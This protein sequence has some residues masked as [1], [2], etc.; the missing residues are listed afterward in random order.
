[1]ELSELAQN[2]VPGLGSDFISK[3]KLP[4]ILNDQDYV[5]MQ[6]EGCRELAHHTGP[7]VPVY[8]ALVAFCGLA[9]PFANEHPGWLATMVLLTAVAGLLRL[10]LARRLLA[11][12]NGIPPAL[13]ANYRAATLGVACSWGFF[14]AS[15]IYWYQST[16]ASQLAMVVSVGLTAGASSS[17]VSDLRLFQVYAVC[18]LLPG[19]ILLAGV[20]GQEA[21]SCV[22][23]FV[24][25]LFIMATGRRHNQR[26][27]AAI[28][29]ERLLQRRTIELE[30]ANLAKSEFVA[31]VSHE[32]RTPMNAIVGMT[33]LLLD[34]PLDPKQRE[35]ATTLRGGCET[36]LTIINDILDLSKME[37]T[38]LELERQPLDLVRLLQEVVALFEPGAYQRGLLLHH[39]W[40]QL[41]AAFWVRG[42]STRLRQVVS[43][44]LSNA[45]KF[46][47]EGSVS[48]KV[49]RMS[50]D[51]IQLSIRDTG[52]GLQPDRMDR[53]FRP[54]SQQDASITR[55]YGGTGLGLAVCDRLAA[56]MGGACWAVSG[57]H[58]A[59]RTPADFQ[60]EPLE[61]GSEFYFRWACEPC[62]P[63]VLDQEVPRPLQVAPDL[64]ILLVEDNP[65]NR[66]VLSAMLAKLGFTAVMA[67][68]GAEA[69]ECCRRGVFD[70]IFMDLQ[71]PVMDG[72]TATLEIRQ[73]QMPNRPWVVALTAN[74]RPEDRQRC[75]EVGMDEF[76]CKPLR[77]K[78]LQ[79]ALA[80][81]SARRQ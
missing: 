54:F 62:S 32:I 67:E 42:D 11:Q 55:R 23:L 72:A 18:M 17:L 20:G 27:W 3:S 34:T 6:R 28:R 66:R 52:I 44:L 48:L 25:L 64:R 69:V 31:T 43:N 59:G 61:K 80:Q 81:A 1:M 26:Y 53:L 47:E 78:E 37:S 15:S 40:E 75:Q 35:W 46:T 68:D 5:A 4:T 22:P 51:R 19:S 12:E 21:L 39:D 9:S 79:A 10:A 58:Q 45:L 8:P 30:K 71:M 36:L 2:S 63:S 65:V 70:V 38:A 50:G 56:L 24:F 73:L 13:I 49:C 77:Q 16:W 60:G 76:L 33:D 41:G 74:T 29:S 7:T 14:N 57:E